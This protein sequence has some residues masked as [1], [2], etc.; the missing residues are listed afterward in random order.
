MGKLIVNLSTASRSCRFLGIA[1]ACVLSIDGD[2][3]AWA[4]A[5][6]IQLARLNT[7]G[8]FQAGLQRGLYI[9]GIICYMI[10]VFL[11]INID[12]LSYNGTMQ[13]IRAHSIIT[14]HCISLEVSS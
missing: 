3:W 1:Q 13:P 12:R 8:L 14:E 2:D 5:P 7:K 11:T 6:L 4:A 10:D 9:M